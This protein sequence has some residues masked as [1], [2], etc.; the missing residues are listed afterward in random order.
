MWS[1][2]KDFKEYKETNIRRDREMK[3]Q[4]VINSKHCIHIKV[5]A[6]DYNYKQHKCLLL[7]HTYGPWFS[8]MLVQESC[9]FIQLYYDMDR[10]HG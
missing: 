10:L 7:Y 9:W 8:D 1:T 6:V 5:N 2:I 3:G 4:K